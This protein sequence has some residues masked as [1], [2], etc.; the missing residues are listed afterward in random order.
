VVQAGDRLVAT[1]GRNRDGP[2]RALPEQ[3]TACIAAVAHWYNPARLDYLLRTV[4]AVRGQAPDGACAIVTNEPARLA[5]DL[6][7]TELAGDGVAVREVAPDDAPAFL[8][9]LGQR[10]AV[11]PWD[12][13]R[14]PFRLPWSH[15]PI[16]RALTTRY[17]AFAH[18][19]SHL[20]YL[21][22]DLRLADG[23]LD[24]WCAFRPLLAPFGLLP[25]FTRIEGEPAPSFMTDMT[26]ADP[27]GVLPSIR[28]TM[29]AAFAFGDGIAT[30]VN[31][32]S[33]YQACSVL[34]AELAD[35]H[36]R[37][38][39]FRSYQRSRIS[40]ELGSR[41]NIRERAAA[42]A[43][44]DH[45][46]PGF[47]SRNVVALGDD[48]G[49]LRPLDECLVEHLPANYANDPGSVFGKVPLVGAFP[50]GER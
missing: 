35:E 6:R 27:V 29:P 9:G 5:G 42:G 37:A 8:L 26:E 48:G 49:R 25:G 3:P 24:Y 20:V 40:T 39:F 21:E 12:H 7:S 13:R 41:W 44:F 33:P 30:C 38:S 18:G 15:K 10:I 16:F 14:H 31:L 11:V 23:A 46:P 19:V 47:Q 17:D 36:F 4:A 43:V 50:A 34:D 28:V 22:D 45:V 2:A 1:I 32:R